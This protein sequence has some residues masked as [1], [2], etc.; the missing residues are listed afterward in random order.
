MVFCF[1][2]RTV[3]PCKLLFWK[4]LRK[5]CIYFQ[6]SGLNTGL[7]ASRQVLHFWAISPSS[8][9]DYWRKGQCQ[10]CRE[11]L[12]YHE[13]RK[14]KE[15]KD[16]IRVTDAMTLPG[17]QLW[18]LVTVDDPCS[19]AKKDFTSHCHLEYYEWLWILLFWV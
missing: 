1:Y 9:W 13:V 14:T 10:P 7:Y 3:K 15:N 4:Q 8:R 12:F 5:W 2:W 11:L 16:T 19:L 6:C 17:M 18:A